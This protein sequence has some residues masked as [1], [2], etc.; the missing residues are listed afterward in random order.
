MAREV[1]EQGGIQLPASL[2]LT[3]T[4]IDAQLTMM[5]TRVSA[6]EDPGTVRAHASLAF[7]V[8]TGAK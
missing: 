6:G 8:L 7:A 2:E 3:A 5:L 4:Y 1:R